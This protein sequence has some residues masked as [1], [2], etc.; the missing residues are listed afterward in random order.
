[1][2]GIERIRE[3]LGEFKTNYVIIGG[4]AVNLNLNRAA[5][6]E[7]TTK[8]VDII[9][10]CEAL[11]SDYLAR[12]WEMIRAGGYTPATVYVPDGTT[13]RV[14]YRF[15]NPTDSSFPDYIELFSRTIDDISVPENMHP[16]HINS[17]DEVSSISALLLNDDYYHYAVS[18]SI[19]FDGVQALNPPSLILLKAKAYVSNYRRKEAGEDVRQDN[20]DKHK[21]DVYRMTLLMDDR[22]MEE[23]IIQSMKDDLNEFIRLVRD[24]PIDTRAISKKMG[25]REVGM[26]EFLEKLV[27]VFDLATS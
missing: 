14:L 1:M 21:R 18:H 17:E 15:V 9:V 27:R 23:P 26:D 12:F 13:R 11:T 3:F 2:K 4:T 8:D 5:L 7:R 25:A 19:D 20:I 6:N 16:I 24:N 10:I 22:P